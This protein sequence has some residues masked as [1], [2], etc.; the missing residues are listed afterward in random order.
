MRERASNLGGVN[1]ISRLATA[2]I[3][4]PWRPYALPIQAVVSPKAAYGP[5]RGDSDWRFKSPT[6]RLYVQVDSSTLGRF[7]R[8][9]RKQFLYH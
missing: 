8:L 1:A 9:T 3:D 7:A 4:L 6:W 5:A 2:K